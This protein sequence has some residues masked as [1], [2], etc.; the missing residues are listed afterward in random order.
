MGSIGTIGAAL[1]AVAAAV[2]LYMRRAGRETAALLAP[3][4]DLEAGGAIAMA[5]GTGQKVCFG[6]KWDDTFLMQSVCS[7][8][9]IIV[10]EVALNAGLM[11]KVIISG[12]ERN[13]IK[14]YGKFIW[15]ALIVKLLSDFLLTYS[16]TH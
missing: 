13:R 16:S 6:W 14:Y 8:P 5:A 9:K 2:H 12:T 15:E 10:G 3:L 1:V 11:V 4:L 7:L